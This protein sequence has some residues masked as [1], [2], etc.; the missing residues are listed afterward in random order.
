MQPAGKPCGLKAHVYQ[1]LRAA[2]AIPTQ[3]GKAEGLSVTGAARAVSQI[4]DEG[5]PV[6]TGRNR[7]R[8]TGMQAF[9]V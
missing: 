8:L 1:S 5:F 7:I 9:F 4:N 3:V 6:N 2:R